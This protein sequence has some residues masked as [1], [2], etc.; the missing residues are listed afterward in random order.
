MKRIILPLLKRIENQKGSISMFILIIMIVFLP[1]TIWVG[2]QLPEKIQATYAIKQMAMNTAD[3]VITRLDQAALSHGNVRV[4]MTEGMEVADLMIRGTL[5]LDEEG[6]PSGKGVLKEQIPIHFADT[7]TD[8]EKI[9][10]PAT[11][12]IRYKLPDKTGVYVYILNEPANPVTILTEN[13]PIDI[14]DTTVIVRANIPIETGGFASRTMIRKTGV[15]EASL[16][17]TGGGS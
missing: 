2:V 3:S 4:D 1:F 11:G 14:E 7:V 17:E 6:N 16:N 8:L 9:E 10:N 5:N 13:G 15:A 12:E